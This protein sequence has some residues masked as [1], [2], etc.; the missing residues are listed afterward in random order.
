M[1][2]IE[3][4]EK[5]MKMVDMFKT[6]QPS[7][8]KQLN[9]TKRE[10]IFELMSE[11]TRNLFDLPIPAI[12]WNPAGLI[13]PDIQQNG[14]PSTPNEISIG[15]FSHL[16][17]SLSIILSLLNYKFNRF[18]FILNIQTSVVNPEI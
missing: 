8:F 10:E 16:N 9:V 1:F 2:E 17:R 7:A 3:E 14:N 15:L 5:L 18:R 13:V 6:H 4:K 12:G 11:D